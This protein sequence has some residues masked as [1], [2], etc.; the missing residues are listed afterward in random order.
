MAWGG[1]GQ[2]VVKTINTISSV[3]SVGGIRG[4]MYL[5]SVRRIRVRGAIGQPRAVPGLDGWDRSSV[6]MVP[7]ET[8]WL[9]VIL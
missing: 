7:V 6:V 2:A 1:G 9:L 3:E 8:V 4:F 5:L